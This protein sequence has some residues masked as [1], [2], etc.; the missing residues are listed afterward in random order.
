MNILI[1]GISGMIG[2]MLFRYLQKNANYNIYGT[3]RTKTKLKFFKSDNINNVFLF[4]NKDIEQF[5]RILN[6]TKPLVVI[7]CIGVVKQNKHLQDISETIYTNSLF[8]NLL[9]DL[10][11]KN[12]SRLIH[13]STD[14]VF[15][16][17]DGEYSETS[18]PDALDIYGRTKYLGELVSTNSLII[19]TSF[20]GHQ[21]SNKY[22]LLEWFLKQNKKCRG[23]Y[24]SIYSGLPTIEVAEVI[25]KYIIPKTDLSGLFH[26]SS[27]PI[28]KFELLTLIKRRYGLELQVVK[29]KNF[30]INRSLKYEKLKLVINY[31]PPSWEKLINKMFEYRDLSYV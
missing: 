23:Y 25:E 31:E 9:S 15:S 20:I 19:R 11:H 3:L 1:L 2:H 16:G 18:I 4:N 22:S 5:K 8:P 26:L 29:D 17:K 30:F 13:F 10:C 6:T 12:S 24:N 14:C 21:L 28:R 7:N 27:K